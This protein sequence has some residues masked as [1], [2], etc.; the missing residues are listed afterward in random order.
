MFIRVLRLLETA[1]RPT[2][3]SASRITKAQARNLPALLEVH[4]HGIDTLVLVK[5]HLI[6]SQ[7]QLANPDIRRCIGCQDLSL[8]IHSIHRGVGV[9]SHGVVS[10]Y[11]ISRKSQIRIDVNLVQ[12][13]QFER[14]GCVRLESRARAVSKWNHPSRI[15]TTS[16]VDSLTIVCNRDVYV[17]AIRRRKNSKVLRRCASRY[18]K[19]VLS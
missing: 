11:R 1:G 17:W 10:G 14:R 12:S 2:I 6:R 16:P 5:G 15:S 9:E 3:R 7:T 4:E 19:A 8:K 13:D 18:E